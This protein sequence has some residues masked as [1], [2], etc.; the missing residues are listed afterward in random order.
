MD[1]IPYRL[2]QAAF[3][4]ETLDEF[5]ISKKEAN[6]HFS[7]F[8]HKFDHIRQNK[9]IVKTDLLVQEKKHQLR[10][11]SIIRKQRTTSVLKQS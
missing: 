1:K 7:R 4:K 2:Q 6:D 11:N 8:Q 5:D 10:M 3:Q 9:A